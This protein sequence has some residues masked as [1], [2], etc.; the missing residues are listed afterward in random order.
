MTILVYITDWFVC[1]VEQ[2]KDIQTCLTEM[3]SCFQLLCP[4]F[5]LLTPAQ[6]STSQNTG[7]HDK[8]A[9]QETTA[10]EELVACSS[11]SNRDEQDGSC[12]EQLG[13]T[14]QCHEECLGENSDSDCSDVEWEEVEPVD[15]ELRAHGIADNGYTLTIELP[16]TLEVVKGED[17]TSVVDTLRERQHLL[18]NNYLP[19]VNRWIQVCTS[20]VP[21]LSTLSMTRVWV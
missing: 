19:A 2:S 3:E 7:E 9:D 14:E 13:V 18:T 16:A 21:M 1:S 6:G 15:E 8:T 12:S 20:L 11:V 10:T 17:N 4:R 5:D